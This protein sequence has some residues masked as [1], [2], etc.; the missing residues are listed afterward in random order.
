[1][2]KPLTKETDNNEPPVE[3][4]T[5]V[6]ELQKKEMGIGFVILPNVKDLVIKGLDASRVRLNVYR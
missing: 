1:M 6:E 4:L 5:T 2:A 3:G